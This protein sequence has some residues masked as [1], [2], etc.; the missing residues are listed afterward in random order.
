MENA[1]DLH[2]FLM[3]T[4][5]LFYRCCQAV[6]FPGDL[7]LFLLG[8]TGCKGAFEV[9]PAVGVFLGF[10][11]PGLEAI[12]T[13]ELYIQNAVVRMASSFSQS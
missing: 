12:L 6:V 13:T 11:F 1:V 3:G 5:G 2:L 9:A 8:Q 10:L 4:F 7:E